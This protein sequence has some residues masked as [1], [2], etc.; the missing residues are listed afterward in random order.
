MPSSVLELQTHWDV[1]HLNWNTSFSFYFPVSYRFQ[2]SQRLSK[3]NKWINKSPC[4]IS[5]QS[6]YTR[7]LIAVTFITEFSNVAVL[8]APKRFLNR[9][10]IPHRTERDVLALMLTPAYA[11]TEQEMIMFLFFSWKG[12]AGQCNWHTLVGFKGSQYKQKVSMCGWKV[13]A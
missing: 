5:Q 11:K 9:T 7:P 6:N 13:E 12:W 1:I 3:I 4:C 10:E 8:Q 2:S